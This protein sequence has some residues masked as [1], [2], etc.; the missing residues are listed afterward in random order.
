M[1]GGTICEGGLNHKGGGGGIKLLDEF[2]E[3]EKAGRQAGKVFP[4]DWSRAYL[5]DKGG[6]F[7]EDWVNIQHQF[8]HDPRAL[9]CFASKK[10]YP[11]REPRGRG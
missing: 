7:P 2:Q 3:G 4:A 9:R 11:P 5:F 6:C 8:L 10:G 1:M